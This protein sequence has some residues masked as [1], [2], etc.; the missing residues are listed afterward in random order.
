MT[1]FEFL[2]LVNLLQKNKEDIVF[3]FTCGPDFTFP[4]FNEKQKIPGTQVSCSRL[5]YFSED[6]NYDIKVKFKITL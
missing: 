2:Q 5:L 3:S 1:H 4:P 6:K